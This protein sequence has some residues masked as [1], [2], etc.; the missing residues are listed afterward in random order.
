MKV[1]ITGATGFI[2]SALVRALLNRGDEVVALTR[3]VSRGQAELGPRVEVLEWYPPYS[4]PW[5]EAFNGTDG[6]VNLA[7]A[8]VETV[9][10][11][12]TAR[13]KEL[14]RSS[15]IDATNA[16]VEALARANPRPSVLVSASG[17]DYYAPRGAQPLAEDAAPGTNFLSGVTQDW[18]AMARRAEDRGVRVVL[19]RTT[20]VLGKGGGILPMM[21][22]PFR[23][24]LGGWIG[25]PR[26]WV[27]W[28]HLDDEVGLIIYALTHDTV[29]GPLNAAAPNPVTMD[30]W[31]RQMGAALHRPALFPVPAPL[32]RLALGE[33]A[34]IALSDRRVVPKAAE[35]AGYQFVHPEVGEALRASLH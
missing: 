35:D 9:P 3:D 25:S 15:R 17:M 20:L 24:Y 28:I 22:L 5:M 12:W 32:I 14:V 16:V 31:A 26:Q 23:F 13:H 18:E 8:T 34:D 19:L 10:I 11:P 33:Q 7:G 30:V 6:V 29:R 2:G 4:G 27:S 21:S 1:I